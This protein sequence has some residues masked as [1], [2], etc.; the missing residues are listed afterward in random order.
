MENGPD[1]CS[2]C[3]SLLPPFSTSAMAVY[4]REKAI[5]KG[6]NKAKKDC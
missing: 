6:E 1:C 2:T 4:F 3:L 5:K